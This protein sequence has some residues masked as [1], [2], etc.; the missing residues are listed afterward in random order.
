[1][2]CIKRSKEQ[3]DE[4]NIKPW[5]IMYLAKPYTSLIFI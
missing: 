5:P 3:Q 1:M 2:S 4:R